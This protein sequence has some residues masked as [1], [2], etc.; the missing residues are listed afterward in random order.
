VTL[1]WLRS[2]YEVRSKVGLEVDEVRDDSQGVFDVDGKTELEF[3]E[4]E[5]NGIELAILKVAG[6]KIVIP[7]QC[8]TYGAVLRPS[9]VPW[10]HHTCLL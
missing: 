3:L 6:E 7:Y 9:L 4:C 10:Y 8:Q 1:E 5:C 2:K